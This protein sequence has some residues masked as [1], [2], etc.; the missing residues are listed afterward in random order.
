MK[1]I[2]FKDIPT[3]VLFEGLEKRFRDLEEENERLKHPVEK[4]QKAE[5]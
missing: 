5:E 2:K 3:W 1:V 4:E